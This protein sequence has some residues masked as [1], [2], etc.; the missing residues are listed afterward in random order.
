MTA[1]PILAA[2]AWPTNADM[3]VDVARLGYLHGRVLDATYGRGRWWT[4]YRPDELVAHDIRLDGIDFRQ[5]P[6]ADGT[7]NAVCFDPPYKLNGTP[8]DDVDGPY[9][10]DVI[11]TRDGRHQLMYD[12][13][14]EC[15]R[16]LAPEGYLLMKCQDQVNGGRVNWQTHMFAKKGEE[17]ELRLVDEL[18]MLAYRP[19]PH[20]TRQVHARRNMSALLVMQAP[21]APRQRPLLSGDIGHDAPRTTGGN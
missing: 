17:L 16:V 5:L 15:A 2:T 21:R 13:M 18:F 11:D 19:Q 7:F 8:T 20:G 3:I 4:K 12:G 1:A 6:H 14:A 10:V 9:G